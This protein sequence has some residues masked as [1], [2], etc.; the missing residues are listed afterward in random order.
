MTENPKDHIPWIGLLMIH[1]DYQGDGLG[2][3]G[4]KRY[5]KVM[6]KR[7]ANQIRF[8][9]LKENTKARS[10]WESIG[11]NYY[12]TVIGNNQKAI[13]YYEKDLS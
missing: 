11:F 8:G 10:F 4:Y 2:S 13:L 9:V 1:R 12:N 5:E 7:G 6:V 3:Q